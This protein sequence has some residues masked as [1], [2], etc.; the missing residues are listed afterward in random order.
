MCTVLPFLFHFYP[1][2]HTARLTIAATDDMNIDLGFW[3]KN[4]QKNL[5][6]HHLATCDGGVLIVEIKTALGRVGE[7]IPNE[8]EVAAGNEKFPPSFYSK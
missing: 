7:I 1:G 8:C 4:Q 3:L 5:N 2:I 6:F